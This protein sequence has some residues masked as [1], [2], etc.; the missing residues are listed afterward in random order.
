MFSFL[1]FKL[2]N[3]S[4]SLKA[5]D[6]LWKILP[7]FCSHLCDNDTDL[8]TG[9]CVGGRGEGLVTSMHS[10]LAYLP[11]FTSFRR[12]GGSLAAVPL[13]SP[14]T[15]PGLSTAIHNHHRLATS[16][17][18]TLSHTDRVFAYRLNIIVASFPHFAQL[19]A[20]TSKRCRGS[21]PFR[22][23]VLFA[24]LF[25]CR[26]RVARVREVAKHSDVFASLT[27]FFHACSGSSMAKHPFFSLP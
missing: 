9:V 23:A 2:L 20:R 22:A 24:R 6:I 1:P 3:F 17:P 14:S 8:D 16:F 13:P 11:P 18:V 15:F 19:S 26:P 5:N 7:I 4:Q 12:A 10:C 21:Y 27:A 25:A